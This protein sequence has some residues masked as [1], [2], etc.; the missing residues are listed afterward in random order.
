MRSIKITVKDKD[1]ER[2]TTVEFEGLDPETF[3]SALKIIIDPGTWLILA[4]YSPIDNQH[5]QKR[6]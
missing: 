4:G 3:L 6:R 1:D 2:E 5:H